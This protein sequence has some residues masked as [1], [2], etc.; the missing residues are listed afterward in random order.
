MGPTVFP[1]LYL[2]LWSQMTTCLILSSSR[3]NRCVQQMHIIIKIVLVAV[4]FVTFLVTE[5]KAI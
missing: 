3:D 1:W 2:Q 5:T 4:V